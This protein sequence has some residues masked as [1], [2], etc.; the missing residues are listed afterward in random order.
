MWRT[1]GNFRLEPLF[2]PMASRR[3]LNV[4]HWQDVACLGFVVEMQLDTASVE[5][6]QNLLDAPL[7]RRMIRA[8]ARDKFFDNGPQR[9]GRQLRVWDAQGMSL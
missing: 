2:I 6:T 9:C 5:L 1:L 3:I 4:V 7:D 8:V